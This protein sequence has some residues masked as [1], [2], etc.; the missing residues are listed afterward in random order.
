MK[1]YKTSF[2]DVEAFH[3]S[4]KLVIQFMPQ[5]L[6]KVE[7]KIF[8]N[9]ITGTQPVEIECLKFVPSAKQFLKLTM[10]KIEIEYTNDNVN[11]FLSQDWVGLQ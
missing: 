9:G 11:W 10:Q 8:E 2:Y 6:K 5:Y 7:A 1:K 3:N 4:G